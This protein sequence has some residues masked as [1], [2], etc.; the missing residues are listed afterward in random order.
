VIVQAEQTVTRGS[1]Q[2]AG[3]NGSVEV[4][5]NAYFTLCDD[6][7]SSD[8]CGY[9]G[10]PGNGF[11]LGDKTG[12]GV[13]DG[14]VEYRVHAETA[15]TFRLY[16]RVSTYTVTP[17]V[18]ITAT[19]ADQKSTTPVRTDAAW[20]TVEATVPITLPAG[21]HTL[22]LTSGQGGNGWILNHLVFQRV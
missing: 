1:K 16:Y 10:V 9:D 15:G 2:S 19:V 20:L 12:F 18:S 4:N 8:G 22:R 13:I 17:N 14:M 6:Y 3:E 7:G 11:R 21:T 5:A